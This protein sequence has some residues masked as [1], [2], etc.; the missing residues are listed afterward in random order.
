MIEQWRARAWAAY[1]RGDSLTAHVL[2]ACADQLQEA[3]V[4][5]ETLH[6][7]DHWPVAPGHELSQDDWDAI[8][9]A[10]DEW[11]GRSDDGQWSPQ[12]PAYVDIP[13]PG[14]GGRKDSGT[15][16]KQLWVIHT[17]ECPLSTGYA[18]SLSLWG[19]DSTV[20]ASWHR[21]S[22]PGTVARFVPPGR[23]AWHATIA[24][25]ISVGYEQAGYAAF[26]RSTWMTPEG[27]ASI[28]RLAQTIVAD[29]IPLSSV[30]RLTDDE[31]RRALNADTSVRGICSH[32]QIQP[33]DRT[34]P[35]A[36]YPW[37]VLL[38]SIK[39]HHPDSQS[40]VPP[41]QPPPNI[42]GGFLMALTD[43]QQANI[44]TRI[45]GNEPGKPTPERYMP[46]GDYARVFDSADGDYLRAT[47][48]ALTAAVK[49]LAAS[50]GADPA[51]IEAAVR[52]SVAAALSDLR[53]V[54]GDGQ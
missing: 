14:A 25:R 1:A 41:T 7:T 2:W 3:L 20:Q 40:Y 11:A 26:P 30:R 4:T 6:L 8:K 47:L 31:V 29:G 54:G 39:R 12:I 50:Q 36:G 33:R 32:A 53:I 27:Q 49:V 34:D 44:Y 43:A 17:A 52:E 37:D 23:A 19:A 35:G 15:A 45:M 18:R 28:D 24:N 21:M 13:Y 46:N 16:T 42:P 51:V 5:D 22:D 48:E 9:A 38:D 10:A